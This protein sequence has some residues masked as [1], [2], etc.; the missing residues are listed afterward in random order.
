MGLNTL[1]HSTPAIVVCHGPGSYGTF[2]L[3]HPAKQSVVPRL[4]VNGPALHVGVRRQGGAASNSHSN[5]AA[6][7]WAH[8]GGFREASSASTSAAG[9]WPQHSADTT[10]AKQPKGWAISEVLLAWLATL[11]PLLRYR[12]MLVCA[13][14]WHFGMMQSRST[15]QQRVIAVHPTQRA[16]GCMVHG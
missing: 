2:H 8:P 6:A 11:L 4:D 1:P 10:G 16:G 13:L 5:G 7:S 14:P 9:V 3:R 15:V 12:L